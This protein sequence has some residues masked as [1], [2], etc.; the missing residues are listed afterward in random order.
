MKRYWT[1]EKE[2]ADVV[3]WK[4]INNPHVT[5]VIVSF[6]SQKIYDMSEAWGYGYLAVD[7]SAVSNVPDYFDTKKEGMIW[8]RETMK[9][10]PRGYMIK[11]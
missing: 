8:A 6:T 1:L 5:V 11:K 3:R 7:G 9:K 4:N 10:Y 2:T